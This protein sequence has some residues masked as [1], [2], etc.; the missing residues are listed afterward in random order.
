MAYLE[1]K[2]TNND[3]MDL[4]I[5]KKEL[6]F[7]NK[8]KKDNE[9]ELLSILSGN[10]IS[11]YNKLYIDQ[12]LINDLSKLKLNKFRKKNISTLFSSQVLA[13]NLNVLDNIE[14]GKLHFKDCINLDEIVK[15]F[16]LSKKII[17]YPDELSKAEKT[18]VLLARALIK[19]P[20]ILVC[21]DIL[22]DLDKKTIK[23]I[24]NAF[25]NYI[26]KYNGIIILS[27]SN[28]KLC[29]TGNKVITYKNS[30]I[31]KIKDNKKIISVGD[32]LC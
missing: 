8:S 31:V 28:N 13:D 17:C 12:I 30:N 32:L 1:L 21:D 7:V 20:K 9:I 19:K 6:I 4:K 11:D 14:L 2:C 16:S 5:N 25:L 26:K 22:D 3:K 29:S 18:K 24:I 10:K 23:K 15:S 27:T